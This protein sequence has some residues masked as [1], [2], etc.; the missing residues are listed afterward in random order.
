MTAR[1]PLYLVFDALRRAGCAPTGERF[2]AVASC[3]ACRTAGLTLKTGADGR[4]LLRCPS[5]CEPVDVAAALGLSESDLLPGGNR[6]LR[7]VGGGRD[8]RVT[9]LSAVAV[10]SVRWLWKPFVPLGKVTVLAGP[11]GISKSMLTALLAGWVSRGEIDGDVRS[12]PAAVLLASAEDDPEDT[13]KP[14]LLAAGADV[15]RVHLLDL[16]ETTPE[17]EH[18]AG[19]IQ[20]PRDAADIAGAVRE[21]GARLVVLDP[22]V[23]FLDPDHS[24]YSEQEVRAALAP[25][26]TLA[27]AEG[28]AVLVVMH[29]NKRDGSDPLR[30]IANSGAFTA[31]ARSVLLLGPDPEAEGEQVDRRR[32]LTAVKGNVG[33]VGTAGKLL[34]IEPTTV[35]A[36]NGETIET[37]RLHV[38]G[39]TTARAEDL[40]GE[41]EDRSALGDAGRFLRDLLMDGPVLVREVKSAAGDAAL[42]WRTVERAKARIGAKAVKLG[43]PGSPWAWALPDHEA[44]DDDSTPASNGAP[45]IPGGVGGLGGLSARTAHDHGGL[46]KARQHSPANTAK[47]ANPANT[48]RA[49]DPSPTGDDES[50]LA[51]A[52]IAAFDA[53]EITPGP[54]PTGAAPCAYPRHRGREWRL[55]A[56]G[57]VRCGV[58]SPPAAGLEVVRLAGEAGR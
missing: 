6:A 12:A 41:P 48:P 15:E 17:G 56:G 55:A 20:L 43:G 57:P 5:G 46:R 19:L 11:P 16:R 26:K 10:R 35:P 29:L 33:P 7:L 39:N 36:E 27:E 34:E 14:R 58:C 1:D 31:L 28:C 24:A 30:R 18:V 21:T 23:A 49:L 38:I 42:G 47:T 44:A 13:V 50:A 9:P 3:P 40:L 4:A 22:V 32:V 54:T 52:L 37:A 53:E 8:V 51:E 25:L 45:P 2:D